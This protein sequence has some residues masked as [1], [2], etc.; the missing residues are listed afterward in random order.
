MMGVR[1]TRRFI[2][3][4]RLTH[5][6]TDRA[7]PAGGTLVAALT[8]VAVLQGCDAAPNEPSPD[9][10]RVHLQQTAP[11]MNVTSAWSPRTAMQSARSALAAGAVAGR[12][13]AIG[14]NGSSGPKL[15]TLEQYDPATDTWAVKSPLPQALANM[16]GAQPLNGLLYVPGGTDVVPVTVPYLHVYDPGTNKWARKADMPIPSACGSSGV[17][18]GRLYVTT[19][20]SLGTS[21]N[22]FHV[23]NPVTDKW[24][25]LTSSRLVHQFGVGGAISGRFYLAGGWD[26]T[27]TPLAELEEYDPQSNS[28]R[29]LAPM[30]VPTVR[31]SATVVAGKLVI[32]GD[33]LYTQIYDQKTNSWVRK[34]PLQTPR[35]DPGVARLGT[36]AYA[37]GGAT[38]GGLGNIQPTLEAYDFASG[39]NACDPYEPDGDLLHAT[40]IDVPSA[41]V[42]QGKICTTTDTDFFQF[43]LTSPRVLY[44]QLAPPSGLNFDVSLLDATGRVLVSATNPGD[45]WE[46]LVYEAATGTYYLKVSGV[47]GA[48]DTTRPYSIR[49]PSGFLGFPLPNRIPVRLTPGDAG[50]A[51]NAV[52]DHSNSQLGVYCPNNAVQAFTGEAGNIPG[53]NVI[54]ARCSANSQSNMLRAYGQGG[55]P[56]IVNG[57]YTGGGTPKELSYDGHPGYDFRTIDQ[58]PS[59]Q[60]P[61]L[62]AADGVVECVST[63]QK[64]RLCGGYYPGAVVLNHNNGYKTLY[65]HL[66]LPVP[67]AVGDRVQRKN[68]VGT[69]NSTGTASPHLHFEVQ[70]LVD[71]LDASRGYIPVDPYGWSGAGSDP[72][73]ILTSVRNIG[74][75]R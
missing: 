39:P 67:V 53:G 2:S 36:V 21:T 73:F 14:G 30:P 64:P 6:M 24:A 3:Q 48:F 61:V 5:A 26:A 62:A 60:I 7:E 12:L 68:T 47:S 52:F 49:W 15:S 18:S 69:S 17:I 35:F 57:N 50:V 19:G 16:N 45:L 32:V 8:L 41:P 1:M 51:I 43:T 38:G 9:V 46:T 66:L 42:A 70:R 13:Y 37:A 27:G 10:A 28:W 11:R 63:A 56:F 54:T 74:L 33:G 72:Y 20:C 23:Y 29:L 58:K 40:I 34:P 65:L 31:A 59:G 4:S 75:W 25:S 44:I 22:L 55:Q 71:L